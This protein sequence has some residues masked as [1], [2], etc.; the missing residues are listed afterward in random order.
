MPGRELANAERG[1]A[2][3]IVISVAPLFTRRLR[4]L[5]QNQRIRGSCWH[6]ATPQSFPGA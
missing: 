1:K 4:D 5:P 3:V 6:D 2:Q